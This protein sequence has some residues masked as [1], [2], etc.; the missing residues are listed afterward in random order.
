MVYVDPSHDVW[1]AALDAIGDHTLLKTSNLVC[2]AWHAYL[3]PRLMASI[4]IKFVDFEKPNADAPIVKRI[5]YLV[6]HLCLEASDVE[7]QGWRAGISLAPTSFS[8]LVKLELRHITFVNIT[9]LWACLSMTPKTLES[10]AI[11]D[12]RCPDIRKIYR[13]AGNNRSITLPVHSP[14]SLALRD[15]VV[16]SDQLNYFACALWEWLAA[17]PTA[18]VLRFLDIRIAYFDQKDIGCLVAFLNSAACSTEIVAITLGVYTTPTQTR[19]NRLTDQV[20]KINER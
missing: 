12:C 16:D 4:R 14:H 6:R 13:P 1:C 2:R 17:S 19:R 8:N 7:T 18:N 10:L 11:F 9:D 3:Q 5:Q 20:R 15:I